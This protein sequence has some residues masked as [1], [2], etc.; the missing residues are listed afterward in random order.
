MKRPGNGESI[1][2]HYEAMGRQEL[3]FWAE[4]VATRARFDEESPIGSSRFA[5]EIH[6][7]KKCR[8]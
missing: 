4:G 3:N 6:P 8:R 1:W 7:A 5:G 2:T